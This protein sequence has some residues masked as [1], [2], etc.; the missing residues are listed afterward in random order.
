V[1]SDVVPDHTS[2]VAN[3]AACGGTCTASYDAAD[4][5]VTWSLD[6]PA[7]SSGTVS[8]AVTVDSNTA[9]GTVITNV[10]HLVSGQHKVP[11]N[12]VRHEVFVPNGDL[13]LVKSVN[14]KK[15]KPGTQLDYTLTATASGNIVQ[16]DVIVTDEVP[17]GTTYVSA[18]CASPCTA[19]FSG[20]VVTWE[21]GDMSPGD[22]IPL[23][24]SVTVDGPD[25]NGT[26]PTSIINVGHIKS[27]ETPREPS[28][29]VVVPVTAV[30]GEK[31]VNT[32]P[33]TALP[34]TGLNA[35]QEALFAAVL[36][37]AGLLLLTWPRL[38][39]QRRATV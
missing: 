28:N 2:Y 5:T 24:F 20:G 39:T 29:R 37:G 30:L 26:V 33:A 25:A 35:L 12:V 11:S 16:H 18:G 13:Q 7:H 34:F 31:I 1:I 22:S 14:P 19:S 32:P 23:G 21:L 6:I 8:F 17:A 3:S 9:D 15:A 10:G 38:Y 4:D 27:T 36:I